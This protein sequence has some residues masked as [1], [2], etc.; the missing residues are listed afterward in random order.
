VD[1]SAVTRPLRALR[2]TAVAG[3]RSRTANAAA[4]VVSG[5]DPDAL[6]RPINAPTAA[7]GHAAGSGVGTVTMECTVD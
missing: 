6:P 7:L 1:V 3:T 4:I 2:V 5:I